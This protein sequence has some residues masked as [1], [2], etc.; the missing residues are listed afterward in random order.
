MA[1][2][3]APRPNP[4]RPYLVRLAITVAISVLFVAAFNEIVYLF[5][6]ESYDRA[7]TTIE[8]VI[9]SGTAQRVEAGESVP[10]IPDEMVFV[11]GDTL[12]VRNEDSVP[13][14]LGP[15][16]V[17]ANSTGK[18]LMEQVEQISLSCSFRATR[19]LGVDVRQ[20]TTIATRLTAMALAAPTM[21]A[22]LFIYGLLIFPIRNKTNNPGSNGASS[23]KINLSS[24]HKS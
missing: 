3:P 18:L 22:L 9:P 17:P 7:P 19:Y 16:W 1:V 13:H 6:K 4:L 15:I 8:L 11:V 10:S 20:P 23:E 21:A 2:F 5:Q 14:Q 12:Q 24:E